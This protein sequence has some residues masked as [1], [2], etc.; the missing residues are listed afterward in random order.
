MLNKMFFIQSEFRLSGN[1][2]L[3]FQSRTQPSL[4]ENRILLA[5]GKEPS[6]GVLMFHEGLFCSQP[7][8]SHNTPGQ[9]I[10]TTE[11]KETILHN[12]SSFHSCVNHVYFQS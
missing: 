11:I 4:G 1:L 3:T 6:E 8:L 5:L 7:E 10:K 12:V 9:E 2:G